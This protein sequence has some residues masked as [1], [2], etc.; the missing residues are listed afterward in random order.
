MKRLAVLTVVALSLLPATTSCRPRK[1]TNEK[2]F[3]KKALTWT[4]KIAGL[5]AALAGG[6]YVIDQH[7]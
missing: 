1:T 5:G 6:L 7:I 4:G 3:A 2:N